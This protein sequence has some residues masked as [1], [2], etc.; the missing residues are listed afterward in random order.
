LFAEERARTRELEQQ[1]SMRQTDQKLPAPEASGSLEAARLVEQG[2]LLLDQGNITAAR[3]ML[4]RAAESGN[5]LALFL[6]AETYDPAIL[7]DWGIFSAWGVFGRFGG[8]R[9]NVTKARGL[10]AKAVAGGVH[11]AKYRLSALATGLTKQSL[12]H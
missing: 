5:T 8:R 7:S 3:S 11:E 9:G 4:K 2:R 6:L 1:L 10:Y 12:G